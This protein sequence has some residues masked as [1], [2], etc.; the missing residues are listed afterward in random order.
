MWLTFIQRNEQQW[1]YHN[2]MFIH[3]YAWPIQDKAKW[4]TSHTIKVSHI[5]ACL[6]D[7]PPLGLLIGFIN[8]SQ[9]VT[10]ITYNT[11]T[12]LHNLHSL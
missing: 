1:F 3:V 10:K 5:I 2:Q 7:W 9:V 12:Y 11:V 4:Q 6:G 8:H